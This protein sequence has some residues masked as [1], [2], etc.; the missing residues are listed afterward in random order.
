MS[1]LLFR[2]HIER[3]RAANPIEDVIGEYVVLKRNG[4][5]L[6]GRSPDNEDL[7]P[8]LSV[9]PDKQVYIDRSGGAP[10]GGDVFHWAMRRHGGDFNRALEILERR[11]GIPP[12]R[13]TDEGWE[14]RVAKEIDERDVF[15]LLGEYAR[16]CHSLPQD[17][18]DE[19]CKEARGWTDETIKH[20]MIGYDDGGAY[21]YFVD[22][23]KI[24]KERALKCG[25]FH[26]KPDGSVVDRYVGRLIFPYLKGGKVVYLTA[27]KTRHTPDEPWESA[28]YKKLA[29]KNEKRPYVSKAIRNDTFFNEDA[30]SGDGDT[31]VITEGIADTISAHQA[32]VDCLSP[33]TTTFREADH[34]KI[35]G[36][37]KRRKR[38]VTCNDNEKGNAGETGALATGAVLCEAGCDVRIATLP[39]PKGL[40]KIDIAD[41]CRDHAP[42]E[43]I[44]VID[45]AVPFIEYKLGKI[46]DGTTGK[47]LEDA[48]KDLFSLVSGHSLMEQDRVSALVR[49]RFK[50]R[51]EAIRDLLK[52]TKAEKKKPAAPVESNSD[53]RKAHTRPMRGQVV[54]DKDYYKTVVGHDDNGRPIYEKISSFV[55]VPS[56]I[57]VV[58]GDENVIA[59]V[60]TDSGHVHRGH[61]FT[62]TAWNSKRDFGRSLTYMNTQFTGS[63]DNVQGVKRI[64]AQHDIPS[65]RGVSV[66]GLHELPQ[67]PRWIA[68]GIVLGPNGIEA[69]SDVVFVDDGA[70]FPSR[71][72]YTLP[73]FEE[74]QRLAR[75]VYPDLVGMNYQTVTLLLIGWFHA[76]PLRQ[77]IMSVLGGFPT[78]FLGGTAES[79]KT[80]SIRRVFWPLS[81]VP[82]MANAA[83][84]SVSATKFALIRLLASSN[85]APIF[86]DEFKPSDMKPIQVEIILRLLRQLHSGEAEERGR[87]DQGI[88]RYDL[89]APVVVAG[90]CRPEDPALVDR[91]VG[92]TPDKNALQIPEHVDAFQRLTTRKLSLLT[93]P[94]LV[95]LLGLN[96]RENLEAAIDVA[97]DIISKLPNS[98]N[99]SLRCRDNMR[100]LTFGLTMFEAF[101]AK[102]GVVLPEL[103]LESALASTT[104]ELMTGTRGAKNQLD[105]FLEDLAVMA[106]ER[107]IEPD[108]DYAIVDEELRICLRPC[109][110]KYLEFRQR[111]GQRE[112]TNGESALRRLIRENHAAS[113]YVLDPS[114]TTSM[115]KENPRTVAIDIAAASTR[116]D[117]DGF[118]MS[119]RRTWGGV[120]NIGGGVK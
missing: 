43:F 38:L 30:G 57:I 4:D 53:D 97:D 115:G 62:P 9:N 41:F 113:G 8:S 95:Y 108:K 94:Y 54:A 110:A 48:L 69:S 31:L 36:I 103:D 14:Q 27:R 46:P 64:V 109:W 92:V 40:E 59:D 16:Y 52:Q 33:G 25:A 114:K 105:N 49:K 65:R 7:H 23:L 90:E 45:A 47:P 82:D 28:P 35:V 11:A 2:E 24:S 56:E 116:L 74:V 75:E 84:F 18:R 10:T 70:S 83:P 51:Q 87:A 3:V 5:E 96:G 80:S 106:H 104:A 15:W 111:T 88:N 60:I 66:V 101:A 78:L 76:A 1:E 102:L 21:R 12:Y 20:F 50:V 117:L 71:L 19:Y 42:E 77:L 98:Q 63:D 58:G 89:S 61:R 112:A 79:G 72:S 13:G 44:A 107:I 73:P 39:R 68:P 91:I 29:T 37:A 100:V 119:A 85:G 26:V 67:G 118:P 55:L 22:V 81:G 99:L 6:V 120:R 93:A 17:V 32:G 86:L 34:T